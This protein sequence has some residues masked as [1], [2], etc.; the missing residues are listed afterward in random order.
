MTDPKT[1]RDDRPATMA[2]V[3]PSIRDV[4]RQQHR[5]LAADAARKRGTALDPAAMSD[6]DFARWERVAVED[7]IEAERREL[8]AEAIKRQ[9][10][11][12]TALRG[13]LPEEFTWV[14]PQAPTLLYDRVAGAKVALPAAKAAAAELAAGTVLRVLLVGPAGS[15]KTTLAGLIPQMMAV[16]WARE[17]YDRE[18]AALDARPLEVVAEEIL[19]ARRATEAAF[20]APASRPLPIAGTRRAR[21][22]APSITPM[23]K[24]C[25]RVVG[26][27]AGALWTTAHKLF[28]LAK[29][30]QGFRE[31]EPLEPACEAALLVLDDIGGEPSQAN[32]AP[33]EDVLRERHDAQRITIAT[34]GMFDP[35][36]PPGD[37]DKL[38]APLSARYGAAVVRRLAEKGRA[39]VIPVGFAAASRAA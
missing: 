10:S 21:S 24:I 27:K 3:F 14:D 1:P 20:D 23:A 2:D 39:I 16:R 26:G 13:M 35:D 11:L 5:Q 32:V 9:R 7:G 28:K 15:G 37:V 18:V 34:T 30:P 6:E 38:L 31:G 36:A 17:R 33:V 8:G 12:A 22:E 4:W 25:A 29:K 19:A